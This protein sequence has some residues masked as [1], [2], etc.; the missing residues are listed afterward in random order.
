MVSQ[1]LGQVVGLVQR[2]QQDRPKG[3]GLMRNPEDI[4]EFED[5][6]DGELLNV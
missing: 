4:D 2:H 6:D 1:V 5:E 3:D